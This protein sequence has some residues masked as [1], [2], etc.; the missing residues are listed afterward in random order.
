MAADL[1]FQFTYSSMR[2][3]SLK[4]VNR[5]SYQFIK[6]NYSLLNRSQK[7]KFRHIP[8]SFVPTAQT[9]TIKRDWHWTSISPSSISYP[10]P[11]S[12]SG[13]DNGSGY[14]IAPSLDSIFVLEFLI[15]IYMKLNVRSIA[16][17]VLYFFVFVGK[18]SE[19]KEGVVYYICRDMLYIITR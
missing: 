15:Q 19:E 8:C 16:N 17:C 6:A 12:L 3:T 4:I 11:S 14:E 2:P 9:K 1:S 10:G 18:R 5:S 7:A 13:N